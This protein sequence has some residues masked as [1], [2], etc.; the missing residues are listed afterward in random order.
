VRQEWLLFNGLSAAVHLERDWTRNDCQR[1][2]V[3]YWP[4]GLRDVELKTWVS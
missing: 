3:R 1:E 2:A 4:N